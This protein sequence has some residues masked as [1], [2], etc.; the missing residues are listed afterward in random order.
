MDEGGCPGAFMIYI[1]TYTKQNEHQPDSLF[2]ISVL[3]LGCMYMKLLGRSMMNSIC[4]F[5]ASSLARLGCMSFHT[6]PLARTRHFSLASS[7]K[8]YVKVPNG[9]PTRVPNGSGRLPLCTGGRGATSRSLRRLFR[10]GLEPP[11][12]EINTLSSITADISSSPPPQQCPHRA[13]HDCHAPLRHNAGPPHVRA[14]RRE[15]VRH[16]PTMKAPPPFFCAAERRSRINGL[17]FARDTLTDWPPKCAP[18]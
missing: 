13:Q 18:P 16:L 4:A 11:I 15:A 8:L 14:A 17:W 7:T 3:L 2:F 12:F 9:K 6:F 5:S 1:Y 10:P